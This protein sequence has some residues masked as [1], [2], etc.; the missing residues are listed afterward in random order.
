MIKENRRLWKL[1]LYT[2]P[3]FGIYS[4][5]F[6]FQFT[7]DLNDM[8]NEEKPLKN[9]ILVLFLS[10]I[11]FGIYRWVW[12]FYLADR[13]QTTGQDMGMKIGPGAGTTLSIRL[14]GT[15]ILIGPLISNYLVIKNMNNVAKEYNS[16]FK[17]NTTVKEMK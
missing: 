3:T 8:N 4:I 10:I 17:K 14:F 12:F 13:I 5:I 9:Y 15:F 11:T 7:K 2:I 1:I 16:N 6:W